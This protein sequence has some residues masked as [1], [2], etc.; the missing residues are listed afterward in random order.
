[1]TKFYKIGI[2]IL[3]L[4]LFAA[5]TFV[6]LWLELGSAFEHET[7]KIEIVELIR[8]GD[9]ERAITVAAKAMDVAAKLDGMDMKRQGQAV[10]NLAEI[11][12]YQGQYT[13]AELLYKLALVILEKNLGQNHSDVA[14]SLSGLAM[15]YDIKNRYAEAEPLFKRA[16]AIREKALGPNHLDVATSLNELADLYCDQLRYAL[17]IR[18]KT[19]DAAATLSDLSMPYFN[20]KKYS[21]AIRRQTPEAT[22]LKNFTVLYFDQGQ[23]TQVEPLFKRALAI[24]EK[25]FGP[26]HPNVAMILNNLAAFYNSQGQYAQAEPLCKRALAIE[27]KDISPYQLNDMA[28]ILK[29]LIYIYR[30]TGQE[31]VAKELEQQV[32]TI[33]WF[34]STQENIY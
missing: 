13:R 29:N 21:Q 25:A 11:Y 28:T 34:N 18:E 5:F 8:H 15:I 6:L 32:E 16:L 7:L 26:D 30:K 12:F 19:L 20:L 22:P 14:K 10:N 33:Q 27:E 23:Y 17:A 31:N 3:L 2:C 24:R 4:L 9:Y 1:M